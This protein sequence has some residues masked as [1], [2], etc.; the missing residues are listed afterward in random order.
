[1]T[2]SFIIMFLVG[3]LFLVIGASEQITAWGKAVI[4]SLTFV[5]VSIAAIAKAIQNDKADGNKKR[6]KG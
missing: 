4:L 3:L 1:M 2:V 5:G 6:Q